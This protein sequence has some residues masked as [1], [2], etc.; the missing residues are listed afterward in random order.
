VI[1]LSNGPSVSPARAESGWQSS[2]QRKERAPYPGEV[3]GCAASG[4]RAVFDDEIQ[5]VATANT[6]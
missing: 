1:I 2:Q 6:I 4:F 3:L 5:I